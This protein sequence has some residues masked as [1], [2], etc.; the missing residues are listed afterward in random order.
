M[1]QD[2]G[3][4]P[5]SRSYFSQ[6][7]RLRY[8]DW[9]NA[10]APPMI[11]LHGGQD[12]CR[13]WDWVAQR[14]RGDWHIIA[15]DLRGHGDSQ[16]SADGNY[17]M[18]AYIYD[19]AQLIHQQQLAPVTIIAHSLGGNIAL[20]Y[21]AIYPG[22]VRQLVAIEGLGPSPK[23]LGQQAQKTI[24]ERMKGWIE[25]KRGLAG[26]LPRRY[27]SIE[28]AFK[29]MQE[30]N[31]HLSPEQA[32]HLTQHGVNQNEDGTY[33][34]KFDNYVRV[35]SPYD[36]AQGEVE[37]LWAAIA[38]PTLL[39]YGKESW[40]S[41]PLEDGRARHFRNAEIV[42]FEKAGHWVHHDRLDVFLEKVAGFLGQGA[43]SV[44]RSVG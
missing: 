43:A 39:V 22:S 10:G 8:V 26:R 25:A 17:T 23:V 35:W 4:G 36:L 19:L 41:N 42:T 15:P 2:A 18:A 21:A 12:H 3:P 11:L 37:Q 44:A 29:R 14:L 20:R 32:R 40:A 5:T 6:R 24:A 30:A 38:C 27:A 33:S 28:E 7:L 1:I 13:N 16:W 31:S 34:W 9:G